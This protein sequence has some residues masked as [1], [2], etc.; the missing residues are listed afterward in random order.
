[1]LVEITV[2]T[3]SEERQALPKRYPGLCATALQ[4]AE[5]ERSQR[6]SV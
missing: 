1:M 3:A 5:A 6:V 2:G 4:F